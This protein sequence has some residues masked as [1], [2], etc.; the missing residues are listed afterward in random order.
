M[1]YLAF[2]V[3][4]KRIGVAHSD[5]DGQFAFPV[6]IISN[7]AQLQSELFALYEQ[8]QPAAF[9]V[10]CSD[11]GSAS[12]NSIQK[13]IVKFARDL[14][15][16]TGLPVYRMNEHGTSHAVKLMNM[17][18]AGQKHTQASKRSIPSNDTVDAGAATLILQR[19]LDSRSY[20]LA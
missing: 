1:R 10:G 19:Y 17:A 16:Q 2:D 3:G 18:I 6:G 9:V 5:D 4:T 7:N 11:S 12:E 20:K 13:H 15:L 8:Y 14:E